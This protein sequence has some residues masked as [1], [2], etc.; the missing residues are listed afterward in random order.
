MVGKLMDEVPSFSKNAKWDDFITNWEWS[1]EYQQARFFGTVQMD[2]VHTIELKKTGSVYPEYCHGWDVDTCEFYPDRKDRCPACAL[3]IKGSYRYF[4]NAID[5][6]AEENRPLKP[7]ADWTP[8]RLVNL[9]P[10]LFGKLKELK[11]VNKGYT[12]TDKNHGAIVQIR[13]DKNASPSDMYNATM[14]TKNVPI[15]EEQES[16]TVLQRFP[17][18]SSK[19]IKGTDG[20][21]ASFEYIRCLNSRDNMIKS[22]R[23]NGYYEVDD[24]VANQASPSSRAKSSVATNTVTEDVDLDTVFPA[25]PPAARAV[26]TKTPYE[27]CPTE[28]GKFASSIECFTKCAVVEECKLE[29]NA[30][31]KVNPHEFKPKAAVVDKRVEFFGNDDDMV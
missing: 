23:R 17:D 12:I 2:F 16:Y 9:T 26:P 6:E 25:T 31:T 28:F 10:S 15:T 14:D 29:T 7:R 30:Q 3:D 8:I 11:S 18:G 5:I 27:E 24:V 21:P 4:M 20:L 13:R 19:I 1:G 22:L